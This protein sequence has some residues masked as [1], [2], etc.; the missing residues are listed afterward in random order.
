M[1]YRKELRSCNKCT[2]GFCERC[3]A[4]NF[5][6]RQE[7]SIT[8]N[9]MWT[10][11]VCEETPDYKSLVDKYSNAALLPGYKL[12]QIINTVSPI[13]TF[14]QYKMISLDDV[15]LTKRERVFASLFIGDIFADHLKIVSNYLT[16]RDYMG[17][18]FSVS[19]STRKLLKKKVCLIP[20]FLDFVKLYEHQ[21]ESL[22]ALNQIENST[23]DGGNH[24]GGIFADEPGL[25]KTATILALIC[26]S[27]GTLPY[28][29]KPKWDNNKIEELWHQFDIQRRLDN[30]RQILNNI[31]TYSRKL[32]I[33]DNDEI[34][35]EFIRPENLTNIVNDTLRSIRIKSTILI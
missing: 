34:Y 25:G 31:I 16:A 32:H 28:H 5:N 1:M 12:Y 26:S 15:T 22:N 23:S 33:Y 14:E 8:K 7:A 11:F 4:H 2:R 35:S 29:P 21:I 19:R 27:A 6:R 9:K 24:R 13:K 3:L 10:C 17:V 20:G 18:M 30:I